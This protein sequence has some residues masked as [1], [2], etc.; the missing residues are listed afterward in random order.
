MPN[1]LKNAF[2]EVNLPNVRTVIIPGVCHELLRRCP[3][4]E[5]VWCV[6]GSSDKLVTVIHTSCPN[7][8]EVKGFQ[9]QKDANAIKRESI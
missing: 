9:C 4:A 3:G 6:Q 8:E 2:K 5:R 7:V 1:V